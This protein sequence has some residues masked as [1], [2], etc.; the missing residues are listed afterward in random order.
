MPPIIQTAEY[1]LLTKLAESHTAVY[2]GVLNYLALKVAIADGYVIEVET[3][4]FKLTEVGY[5]RLEQL[6]EG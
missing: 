1:N 3:D 5:E 4:Y 6:G 2:I